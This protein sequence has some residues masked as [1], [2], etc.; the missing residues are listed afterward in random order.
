MLSFKER[1]LG[2]SFVVLVREKRREVVGIGL[3]DRE[4]RDKVQRLTRQ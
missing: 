2:G 1:D 3:R 4:R